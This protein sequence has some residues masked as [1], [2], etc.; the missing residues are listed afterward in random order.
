MDRKWRTLILS[1]MAMCVLF[2]Y[3]SEMLVSAQ[4]L[5]S[6]TNIKSEG[7]RKYTYAP[8][9]KESQ[10]QLAGVKSAFIIDALNGQVIYN[11][12]E[13]E[14]VEIASLSKLLVVYLVYKSIDEGKLAL[15]QEVAIS[16]Q[17]YALS[18]DYN[19]ANVPL[20]QDLRY[21]IEDLIEA[22]V[23]GSA[24]GACLALAE[25][26]AGSQDA[27]VQM[28]E[29]QLQAWNVGSFQLYNATGLSVDYQPQDVGS[30][31]NGKTNTMTARAVAAISYHL[32][33]EYPKVLDYSKISKKLFQEDTPDAFEMNNPNKMLKTADYNLSY[34]NLDGLMVTS[35]PED[36][37]SMV[38]T[39]ENNKMR[40]I[41]IVLGVKEENDLYVQS[42]KLLDY[43]AHA[44]RLELAIKAGQE[45]KQIDGI[46]LTNADK[47]WAPL[48]YQDDL[49]LLVPLIDTAPHYQYQFQANQQI[50][51][52]DRL[53]APLEKGTEVGKM[54]I[55]VAGY[56]LPI[57]ESAEGNQTKVVLAEEVKKVN[58]FKRTWYSLKQAFNTNWQKLRKFFTNVFN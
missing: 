12:Q 38:S 27:C 25:A 51:K 35:S 1:C 14:P 16:D 17:A 39:L 2:S 48:I 28:M 7:S 57:L 4:E 33:K 53:V 29:R 52:G 32:L 21:R 23:L 18:Q 22:T 24:N 46:P 58:L 36:N 11:F 42:R 54:T 3:T 10:P 6:S 40:M 43:A 8:E 15:E 37:F 56:P 50:L 34:S 9:I 47:E 55:E 5:K 45:V 30:N 26:L 31:K 13:D 49:Y 20:R 44:Y 41:A 19:I